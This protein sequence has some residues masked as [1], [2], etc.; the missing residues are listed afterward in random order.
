[1]INVRVDIK[2]DKETI[3]KLK[4]LGVDFNNWKPELQNV[5]EYLKDFYSN[6]VFET[7]GGVL[8]SRWAGL[9]PVYDF[10]KR[11]QYPGRG[12]L[13]RTGKLKKGFEDDVTEKS[14]TISN[15]VDYAKFHQFGT[16]RMPARKLID[17]DNPRREKII[18]IFKEG[19]IKKIQIASRR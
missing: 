14:A 2:G 7:E 5:A 11:K 17:I 3:A 12:T 18:D 16:R 10:M 4:K 6:A 8:G 13:V 15:R 19:I 1:M 9:Q